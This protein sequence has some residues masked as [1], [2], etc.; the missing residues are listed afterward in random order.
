MKMKR[1][2]WATRQLLN[3][4]LMELKRD[5]VAC[6]MVRKVARRHGYMK[7]YSKKELSVLIKAEDLKAAKEQRLIQMELI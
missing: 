5:E 2:D 6:K 1:T 4:L 3:E 7:L